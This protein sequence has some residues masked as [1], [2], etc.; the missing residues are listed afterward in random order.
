MLQGRDALGQGRTG[1]VHWAKALRTLHESLLHEAYCNI[2][3]PTLPP[4]PLVSLALSKK[5]LT[6]GTPAGRFTLLPSCR[7]GTGA[8][9]V[10]SVMPV[11]AGGLAVS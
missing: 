2:K 5:C 11:Q 3:H 4:R 6:L 7:A 9:R 10:A 1:S 8:C